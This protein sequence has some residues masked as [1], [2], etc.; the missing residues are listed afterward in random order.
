MEQITLNMRLHG[1]EIIEKALLRGAVQEN[2][3]FTFAISAQSFNDPSKEIIVIFTRVIISKE[4][5]GERIGTITV[6]VGFYIENFNTHFK[7]AENDQIRIPDE[8]EIML[9]SMAL[10]T[11]RGVMFSEFKGTQLH[12]AFLPIIIPNTMQPGGDNIV[13]E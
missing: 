10:S 13:N 4:T 2:E 5:V 6:A 1:I 8:V 3:T 11:T 12:K 7:Q 9:R